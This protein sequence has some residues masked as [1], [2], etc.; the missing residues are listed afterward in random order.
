MV[1]PMLSPWLCGET[2]HRCTSESAVDGAEAADDAEAV[3]SA[4]AADGTEVATE[5]QSPCV[6]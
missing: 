5:M 1:A 2:S 6:E 3:D 4:E